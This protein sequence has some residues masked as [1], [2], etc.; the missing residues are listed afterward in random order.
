[1]KEVIYD[2]AFES[3]DLVKFSAGMR[4]LIVQ[5]PLHQYGTLVSILNPL[6]ASEAIIQQAVQLVADPGETVLSE[7]AQYPNIR[8]GQGPLYL[9]PGDPPHG[10]LNWDLYGYPKT[11]CLMT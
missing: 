11:T 10:L 7:Q 1:M 4:D 2:D 8:R 3:P 5:A 9:K 6:V